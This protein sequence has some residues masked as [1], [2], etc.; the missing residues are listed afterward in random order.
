M[1]RLILTVVVLILMAFSAAGCV[2]ETLLAEQMSPSKPA[3]TTPSM[4]FYIAGKVSADEAKL[5]PID[6]QTL[7]AVENGL[8][9]AVNGP[10]LAV[11]AD[12]TTL[13]I[14]SYARNSGA[15]LPADEVTIRI[16]DARTGVERIRFH[17]PAHVV[18]P[19]LTADGSKLIVMLRNDPNAHTWYV[20]DTSN[21]ELL[22]TIQVEKTCCAQTWLGPAGRRLYRM[23]VPG[24]PRDDGPRTL[25]LAAYD[26]DTGH[27]VGRLTF[28][29]VLAGSWQTEQARESTPVFKHLG[30][31]IALSPDGRLA[32]LHADRD[33]L[34]LADAERLEIVRTAQ[35]SRPVGLLD[36]LGLRPRAAFA[37]M[38]EGVS[39]EAC[40]SPDGRR[41]Y[42]FGLESQFDEKAENFSYHGL[43]LR[44]I[45]VERGAIVAEAL[46]G[47]RIDWVV[48][49]PD[50]RAIYIFGPRKT[51]GAIDRGHSTYVL[52]RLDAETL[53]V[54]A[55]REFAGYRGLYALVPPAQ[56]D[57][58]VAAPEQ[59]VLKKSTPSANPT[60]VVKTGPESCPVTQP[61]DPAFIPPFGYPSVPPSKS[62]FWYGTEALWTAVP[63]DGTWAGLPH[64]LEGYTQKVFW[65]REGYNW[66][67]E[68]QPEL[69]VTGQRL[70]APA[71]PPEVS[72]ATN[73]FHPSFGSAMLVGMELPAPGCWEITGRY[74]DHELSFVV[75]IGAPEA[76]V[77]SSVPQ[78]GAPLLVWHPSK[79]WPRYE[80]HLVD[81]ATDR[82]VAGREPIVLGKSRST[83]ISAQSEDGGMLA[84]VRGIGNA[85]DPYAGGTRCRPSSDVLHL[86]NL[87][88]WRE[89]SMRLPGKGRAEPL[90]FSPDGKRLALAYH[91]GGASTLMLVDATTGELVGEQ[92]LDVPPALL[93]FVSDGSQL[94]VYGTPPSWL[95][96]GHPRVLLLDAASLDVVWGATLEEVLSGYWCQDCSGERLISSWTPGV[97]LSPDRRRLY[98]VHADEERLTTVDLEARALHSVEVRAERD[99]GIRR[100]L[101]SWL[102]RLVGLIADVAHAKGERG[103]SASKA[104]VL[105]PDGSRLYVLGREWASDLQ[106]TS[107]MR[108]MSLLQLVDPGS[109]RER[110]R[111]LTAATPTGVEVTPDG[112]YVLLRG[113]GVR[114]PWTEV[115]D[116][117]TLE[118]VAQ[119][120]K[121]E[122]VVGRRAD[123]RPILLANQQ[124]RLPRTQLAV[125]DPDSLEVAHSWSVD[126][127]AAW[128]APAK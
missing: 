48:P 42:A 91:K 59:A 126:T 21:G 54:T 84:V 115:L 63:K 8:A 71:P 11:S 69:T 7:A 68:P 34:T 38:M 64:N 57:E 98:V 87:H 37:K 41:L 19:Q 55:E 47:E 9:I 24:S 97:I 2:G 122:V 86:I 118:R 128:V 26:L 121:W 109:G 12:G 46:K 124:P 104:P 51:E 96:P 60:P 13:A 85:C 1:K 80:V 74:G 102:D 77:K 49:A 75:W 52:R 6:P 56:S 43:G 103:E 15:N 105:S 33:A 123:G 16:L 99:R 120:E 39:W 23:I 18:G 25:E 35:L 53:K 72:R 67:A 27:E 70:D 82:A 111:H 95:E 112:G 73:A 5:I 88:A 62:E 114:W 81:P 45:D 93:G 113:R 65:W 107:V 36:R 94:V 40:F 50:G 78:T 125:L 79:V 110:A 127:L 17:P 101:L 31:G 116:A 100:S 66:R 44:V 90:A 89:V 28:D 32:V 117:E 61:P 14:I 92:A 108:Y 20:L 29:G 10:A 30:P 22:S 106:D 3:E 76:P 4:R 83:P 58:P 119:V